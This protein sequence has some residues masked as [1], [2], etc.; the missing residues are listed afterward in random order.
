M[1]PYLD[2]VVLLININKTEFIM[3]GLFCKKK[4]SW[5]GLDISSDAI[6]ILQLSYEKQRYTVQLCHT[7]VRYDSH[8]E[9][10]D[11]LTNGHVSQV[12]KSG[13]AQ[14]RCKIKLAAIAIP[15][16]QTI[17]KIIQVAKNL[18]DDEIEAYVRLE[19]NRLIPNPITEISFDFWPIGFSQGQG[20]ALDILLVMAKKEAVQ[21]WIAMLKQASLTVK[22]VEV[23]SYAYARACRFMDIL[24]PC[25]GIGKICLIIDISSTHLKFFAIR[26]FVVIYTHE[27]IFM[28]PANSGREIYIDNWLLSNQG[29]GD[30]T[31]TDKQTK[32]IF[33]CDY[34][35]LLLQLR[36]SLQLIIASQ[37]V[38]QISSILLTGNYNYNT[39]FTQRLQNDLEL[40]IEI[41]NPFQNMDIAS[42]IDQDNLYQQAPSYMGCCGLATR[43]FI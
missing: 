20:D 29:Q 1:Q 19:A 33:E 32:H 17:T 14:I 27:E 8:R 15:D 28:P 39:D 35:I 38:T 36:R 41:A 13:L 10:K 5:L 30:N 24:Q 40:P 34:E 4:Y 21:K 42:H 12:I 43:Y 7:I 18:T 23:A 22:V 11:A 16:S 31:I 37:K 25:Q 6:R 26:D 2:S 9:N 3:L